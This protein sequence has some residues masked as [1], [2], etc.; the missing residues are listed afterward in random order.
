LEKEL[1]RIQEAFE[2][3]KEENKEG[4]VKQVNK[5]D[6]NKE[7]QK[8]TRHSSLMDKI[9]EKRDERLGKK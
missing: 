7:E 5:V 8:D 6:E 9:R 2:I 3:G 1:N 4:I